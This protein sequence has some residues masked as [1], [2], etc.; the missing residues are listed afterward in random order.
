MENITKYMDTMNSFT[1]NNQLIAALIGIAIGVVLC[2]FGYKLCEFFIG[3]ITFIM[4]GALGLHF[5]SSYVN[6]VLLEILIFVFVGALGAA[7]AIKLYRIGVF[8]FSFFVGMGVIT[9]AMGTVSGLSLVVGVV[10][11]IVLGIFSVFM[12]KHVMIVLTSIAG[13]FYISDNLAVLINLDG[14]YIIAISVLVGVVGMIVQY[15]TDRVAPKNLNKRKQEDEDLFENPD[16]PKEPVSTSK[17]ENDIESM[18]LDGD[19]IIDS[20]ESTVKK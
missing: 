17:I 19:E 2:F 16:K 9:T 1:E 20:A 7:F 13:A 18:R 15:L 14:M 12:T 11:G 6:N 4:A 3:L 5:G 10:A 8:I